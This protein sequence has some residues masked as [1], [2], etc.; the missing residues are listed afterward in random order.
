MVPWGNKTKLDW[1]ILWPMGNTIYGWMDGWKWKWKWK[2]KGIT[3]EN[4]NVG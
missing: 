4:G 3:N 1:N 2:W